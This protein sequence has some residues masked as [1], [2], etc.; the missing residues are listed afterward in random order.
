MALTEV[1][2]LEEYA[3]KLPPNPKVVNIG[4]GGGTSGLAFLQARDDLDLTTVDLNRD[5]YGSLQAELNAIHDADMDGVVGGRFRQILS[6][7]SAAG[8]AWGG[9]DLD[10]VFVDADH[11]SEGC[12]K[13]LWSWCPHVKVGGYVICHDYDNLPLW[14]GV[15]E[16]VDKTLGVWPAW[17]Q[18]DLVR[19]AIVF[20]RTE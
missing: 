18:V 3:R 6:D 13:D 19:T 14:P 2:L 12:S 9:G 16:A 17:K 1:A 7:S 11:S 4:A 8:A 20:Q 10:L 5:G 15:K